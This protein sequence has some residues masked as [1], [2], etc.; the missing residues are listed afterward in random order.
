MKARRMVADRMRR[1]GGTGE[2]SRENVT[3]RRFMLGALASVAALVPLA[4]LA[5]CDATT[6][7][8]Y[9]PVS[10]KQTDAEGTAVYD[11]VRA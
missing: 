5:G 10:V 7:D 2:T 3:R 9:V 11:D 8:V 6:V 4:G 1:A